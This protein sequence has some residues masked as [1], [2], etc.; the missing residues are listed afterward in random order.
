[1]KLKGYTL[2]D[3]NLFTPGSEIINHKDYSPVYIGMRDEGVNQEIW[4]F[5]FEV[6]VNAAG[7]NIAFD[8]ISTIIDITRDFKDA[9][10]SIPGASGGDISANPSGMI[11]T[12]LTIA[13]QLQNI[14]Y[15][16]GG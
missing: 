10:R 14:Y 12:T 8:T 13:V 7:V 2:S 16:I 9:W 6:A 11:G 1:M 5:H 15:H 4:E 3:F